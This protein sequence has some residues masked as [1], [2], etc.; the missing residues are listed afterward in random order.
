MAALAGT[1]HTERDE[2][3]NLLRGLLAGYG[4]HK[5]GQKMGCGCFGTVILFVVL[6]Y[7]LGVVF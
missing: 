2:M 4:A 1:F 5:G 3:A 7:L 6:Y